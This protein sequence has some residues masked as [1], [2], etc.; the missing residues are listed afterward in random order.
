MTSAHCQ[1][2]DGKLQE[3]VASVVYD[4][5]HTLEIKVH[6]L[7]LP[8]K[9]PLLN[10][11]KLYYIQAQASRLIDLFMLFHPMISLFGKDSLKMSYPNVSP[12]CFALILRSVA[13]L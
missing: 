2:C 4:R 9:I 3:T 7:S 6:M 10:L 1:N 11:G 12:T 5:F 13:S 8:T